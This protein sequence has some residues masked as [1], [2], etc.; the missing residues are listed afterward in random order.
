MQQSP[1]MAHLGR[2]ALGGVGV[3]ANDAAQVIADFAAIP[4]EVMGSAK[5]Q[6]GFQEKEANSLTVEEKVR[7]LYPS[8]PLPPII[9]A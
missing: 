9:I 6:A 3:G 5:I 1:A 8:S 2:T 7:F 4:P